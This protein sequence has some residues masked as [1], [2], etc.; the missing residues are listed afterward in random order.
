ME[1]V[2][3]RDPRLAQTIRTPGYT[4]IGQSK[5]LAPDLSVSVTGYHPIK[6]VQDPTQAGG[7]IDRN[8][9]ATCDLPVYRY[10]EVLL[11]FAEAKAELGTLTQADVD[12][13]INEI[14]R[15]VD[16][17]ELNMDEANSHPD[18]YLASAET[19]Y[20]NVIGT[21]KGIILEIRRERA[22]E[23]TQE[24]FRFDDLV[25]WKAGRCIDQA[26]TGMYFPGPGEYDLTGDGEPDVMLY[27]ASQGKPEAASG[28]QVYQLDS[29]IILSDG[30]KG[31]ISY[32]KNI[33]RTPF[34]ENRDYLYPIPINERSLNKNLTQNPGWEDGLDF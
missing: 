23:L 15:R 12:R 27:T 17:P 20:P 28:V 25:R 13:S 6:F 9:Y 4:R 1:E 7:N 34:N 31:Y 10:A 11:N 26:I 2:Q 3:N 29:D 8:D 16:M 32:H 24:G 33:Q 19:G 14:R 21:N 5:V 30:D 18:K 22:I